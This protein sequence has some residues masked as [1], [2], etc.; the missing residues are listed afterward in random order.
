[1]PNVSVDP[2]RLTCNPDPAP[3]DSGQATIFTFTLV[4]PSRWEWR[5]TS[6]VVVTGGAAQFFDSYIDQRTNKVVLFDKN[7][8]GTPAVPV[9]YKYTV[10]V[11]DKDNNNSPVNIDPIIKN[12]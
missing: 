9:N 6:P 11:T 12:Q 8:D 2:S 4:N 10:A 7:T 3:A 5:G 1:M